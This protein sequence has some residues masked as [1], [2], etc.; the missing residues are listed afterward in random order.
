MR[1]P[2]RPPRF[3]PLRR[4]RGM[5]GLALLV[6]AA[7]VLPGLGAAREAPARTPAAASA[8]HAT[9]GSRGERKA[10]AKTDARPAQ[11]R[12][13]TVV[14]MTV[15]DVE[16]SAAF[17]ADALGFTK[18]SDVEVSGPAYERLW[19]VPGLRARVVRMRLGHEDLE[20][21]EY[22]T[23]Q[24][25]PFPPDFRSNVL[26]FQHIAIVVA[27]MEAASAHVRAHGARA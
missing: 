23:P 10:G 4:R 24:G 9:P 17:Y 14:G 15:A 11:V 2:R 1:P 27:D 12:A 21:T 5:G 6:A 20:L 18:V 19:G 22:V 7:L 25:R 13:V 26:W 3:A 8:G 16:R